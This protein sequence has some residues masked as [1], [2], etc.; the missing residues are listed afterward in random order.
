MKEER[1]LNLAVLTTHPIQFQA[2]LFQRMEADPGISPHVY[3][4]WDFGVT[5]KFDEGFGKKIKWDIPLLEGYQYSFLRNY[6]LRETSA[7]FFGCVNPG[8]VSELRKG[9]YDAILILGWQ[10]FTMVVG[11]FTAFLFKIPVLM[12]G[13]NPLNQELLKPKWKLFLKRIILPPLF[14]RISYFLYISEENK[15]FYRYHG[16][17]DEKL[18]FMPYAV[19]N[20]RLIKTAEMLR[21]Q[22]EAL[23][24]KLLGINDARP[25]IL[26]VGKLIEKKRPMDLLQ[27]YERLVVN[28]PQS[29]TELVFVGDGPLRDTLE[30]YAEAKKMDRVH[31]PGFKNQTEVPEY[32]AIADLY[33]QASDVGDTAPLTVNEAMCFSL[34]I[35]ISSRVGTCRDRVEE[36][37]NGFV[38]P[39]AD[40]SKL[41]EKISEVVSS[42]TQ[43]KK[44]GGHS[45]EMIKKCSYEEDLATLNKVSRYIWREE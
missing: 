17:P 27:A 4:C 28:E 21:P 20:E 18:F 6:A 9:R 32:Y 10:V 3:F 41:Y 24:K 31:F 40:I 26:F 2:P 37:E 44:L 5:E 7:S 35:I 43:I 11:L 19:D 30:K 38:F 33:V 1:K 12:R 16:V 29:K 45:L 13:E 23:R 25:V 39:F 15:E 22:R 34:P 8:I 14:K 42:P 36:G